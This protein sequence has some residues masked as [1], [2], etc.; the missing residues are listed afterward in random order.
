MVL[1]FAKPSPFTN[2]GTSSITFAV[3]SAPPVANTSRVPSSEKAMPWMR[4][5][6]AASSSD[7]ARRHLRA[8]RSTITNWHRSGLSAFHTTLESPPTAAYR[9]SAET[10]ATGHRSA[11]A[12]LSRP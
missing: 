6:W 1:S 7:T 12:P 4:V 9:P 8:S 2:P 3:T 10:A 11:S 5:A